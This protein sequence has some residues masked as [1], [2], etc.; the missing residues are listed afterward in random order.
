[1]RP[2]VDLTVPKV[3]PQKQIKIAEIEAPAP[4][5]TLEMIGDQP[6]LSVLT[7]FA[8]GLGAPPPDPRF[9]LPATAD[10]KLA[11]VPG[12]RTFRLAANESPQPRS[13]SYF[14]FNYVDRVNTAVNQ[15]AG[16]DIQ[17][18]RV[19][20]ETFAVEW[21][22]PSGRGSFG[23]RLPLNTFNAANHI[24]GLDGTSTDLGD[25]TLIWK[26]VLWRDLAT[27]N[28]ISA[29]L[30]VTPPTGPG[31]FAGSDHLGGFRN[32]QL[33]PFLGYLWHRDRF[34]AHGFWAFDIPTD[35]NDVTLMNNDLGLGYVLFHDT[36]PRYPLVAVA[37]TVELHVTTP[38]NH[39]GVLRLN[40]QAGTPDVVD[41]TA[42]LNLVFARHSR[43][44]IGFTVP[45]TGPKPFDFGLQ[46]QFSCH[47]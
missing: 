24:F 26:E 8:T 10:A 46:T 44:G 34:Y 32:T 29:G 11:S 21:L 42:G 35:H 40:D 30:A 12:L 37:P 9:N 25:L 16:A 3:Q 38:L 28:L 36:S 22:D 17:H 6:P 43:M 31:A 1:M 33:Q 47:Y 27:G 14:S 20:T 13:R 23:M 41:L 2:S 4:P 39:R 7:S 45:V 18:I 15:R 19:H 5:I